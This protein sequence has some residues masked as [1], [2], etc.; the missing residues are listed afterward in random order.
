MI[1]IISAT[2][3][4]ATTFL[5]Q[6]EQSHFI[7]REAV[8]VFLFNQAYKSCMYLRTRFLEFNRAFQVI[9]EVWRDLPQRTREEVLL[10][11]MCN[12]YA[13]YGPDE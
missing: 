4:F 10:V 12:L 11:R 3:Q 5:D 13:K 7:Y 8:E 1:I 2:L 9:G 6:D